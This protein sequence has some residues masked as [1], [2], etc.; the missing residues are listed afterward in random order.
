MPRKKNQ[1]LQ[2]P[3]INDFP[4]PV[5]LDFGFQQ[6]EV[7]PEAVQEIE[8]PRQSRKK[9]RNVQKAPLRTN[10]WSPIF[11]PGEIAPSEASVSPPNDRSPLDQVEFP[12]RTKSK[13]VNIR[14]DI[15]TTQKVSDQYTPPSDAGL[16]DELYGKS[17]AAVTETSSASTPPVEPGFSV[18]RSYKVSSPPISPAQR[19]VRP[20]SF[21]GTPLPAYARP[22][23]T[24]YGSPPAPHL[25]QPH[26]YGAHDVH[27]GL[28]VQ[29]Q[30]TA[31]NVPT[32]TRFV[33]LPHSDHGIITGVDQQIHVYS[34][35]GT[36]IREIGALGALS[37]TPVDAEMFHCNS[38]SDSLRKL[39]PL[40][41]VTLMHIEPAQGGLQQYRFSVSMYSLAEQRHIADLLH[42]PPQLIRP[43][44]PGY[45]QTS[46]DLTNHLRLQADGVFLVISS[47]KSGELHVFRAVSTET[48]SQAFECIKKLWTALQPKELQRAPSHS[49]TNVHEGRASGLPQVKLH[50]DV[51]I[52]SIRGRWLAV[53]PPN[54][55]PRTAGNVLGQDVLVSRS[56]ELDTTG[57]GN[58]P[59]VNCETDSP[60]ADTVLG[61]VA[62]GV[63]KEMYKAS[64][65][66][67]TQG[68]QAW[69]NYWKTEDV[70]NPSSQR[71]A[72]NDA[73]ARQAQFDHFPPTHADARQ[74]TNDPELVAIYDLQALIESGNRK[75][76]TSTPLVTFRPPHGCSYV[77]FAP[78]GLIMLTAS[79]KGDHHYIWD[80]MEMKHCRTAIS[81]SEARN[82]PRIRQLI[83]YDRVG[84]ST[85]VDVVWELPSFA[86]FALLTKNKTIH[87]FN[88]P[89][90][91][92][93]WPPPRQAKKARPLSAPPTEAIA[94]TH[95]PAPTGG[96]LAS[97]MNFA[98]KTQ[99]ILPAFRGRA[100]SNSGGFS[101]IGQAGF[102]F[103][104]ATGARGSKA[105]ASGLSKSLGAAVDTV[106]KIHHAGKTRLHLESSLDATSGCFVWTHRAGK[107]GLVVLNKEGLK[108]YQVRKRMP[109]DSRQPE[110]TVF[111]ARRGVSAKFPNVSPI[112]AEHAGGLDL[113]GYYRQE[114]AYTKDASRAHPL[115]FAEI[116][117]NA[118]FQPFHS[119]RRVAVSVYV[120]EAQDTKQ[121]K[122]SKKSKADPSDNWVFGGTIPTYQLNLQR[123]ADI[124]D[125]TDSVIYRE[126]S[127]SNDAEEQ[128]V[129]TSRRRKAKTKQVH[130]A[131]DTADDANQEGF[132]EDDCDV[133]DFASDRV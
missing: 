111:D 115:S 127:V 82:T 92:M 87:L 31:Q 49:R 69:Q 9:T 70:N 123:P 17:P 34:Y 10:D 65:W 83:R 63:A 114:E 40:I 81:D 84:E 104:A 112:E 105:V 15:S 90:S 132:F 96:F 30:R 79:R 124:D 110:S 118:P 60:D 125:T 53:C 57:P 131:Q 20:V 4:D 85:V 56:A 91:A 64:R 16:G 102:G 76:S 8:A 72:Y 130:S 14:D 75:T 51:P 126:T 2:Q 95:D 32:F 42:T 129:S 97:A 18:R 25:P 27:L 86:T 59:M 35:N 41:A 133:L 98:G 113:P 6:D 11:E 44:V 58:R 106:S 54:N 36:N 22:A 50:E 74:T 80:L 122:K 1:H 26:F 93:R 7:E 5:D 117:T 23:S 47:A 121:H 43:S 99:P 38:A 66:I 55:A 103:A 100:P 62:R 73:D 78:N 29:G 45:Q 101:G 33:R 13:P 116:D 120:T 24:A 12:S 89:A 108:Y 21:G 46:V 88:L 71:P 48:D 67:G 39:R 28:P 19:S 61:R 109:A 128:I 52:F 77:N 107:A 119:D 94:T 68:M 3:V 37:G